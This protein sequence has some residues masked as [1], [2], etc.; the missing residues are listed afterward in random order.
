MFHLSSDVNKHL[1]FKAKDKDLSFKAKAKDLSFKA[2]VKA[3]TK[4][5]SFK[6]KAMA[7]D[8]TFY[9]GQG[10]EIWSLRTSKTKVEYL[11][12]MIV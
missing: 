5:L 8:L 3:K 9:Q 10:H 1:G 7:K 11:G 12:Q 6:A 4:D 2:K